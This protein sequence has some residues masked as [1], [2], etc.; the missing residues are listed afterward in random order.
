[1]THIYAIYAC[2]KSPVNSPDYTYVAANE[3]EA[4]AMFAAEYAEKTG[5]AT[6][7]FYDNFYAE[8]V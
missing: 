4:L 1:M 6:Q 2:G 8:K 5:Y 7:H 3:N